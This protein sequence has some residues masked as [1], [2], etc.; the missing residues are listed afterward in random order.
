MGG[1]ADQSRPRSRGATCRRPPQAALG[2]PV[3]WYAFARGCSPLYR[4]NANPMVGECCCCAL[5]AHVVDSF[6]STG[7]KTVSTTKARFKRASDGRG[8]IRK[9]GAGQF[10][11]TDQSA[12]SIDQKPR[13]TIVVPARH[14][15]RLLSMRQAVLHRSIN[16][17]PIEHILDDSFPLPSLLRR[18]MSSGTQRLDKLGL[19]HLGGPSFVFSWGIARPPDLFIVRHKQLLD[20]TF[21]PW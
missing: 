2:L 4:P 6:S 10:M 12:V 8:I 20:S 11:R 3:G 9:E 16:P 14:H 19:L 5:L 21:E 13:G 15:V 17:R 1:G 18:R 7:K